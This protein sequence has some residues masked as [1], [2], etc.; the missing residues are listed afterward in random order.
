MNISGKYTFKTSISNPPEIAFLYSRLTAEDELFEFTTPTTS[1]RRM[2]PTNPVNPAAADSFFC[3]EMP[4]NCG[5]Y[6]TLSDCILRKL[7]PK[8]EPQPPGIGE[9][10]PIPA[11]QITAVFSI[12]ENGNI[13]E[14]FIIFKL[15]GTVARGG[16]YGT[17]GS[18]K[19]GYLPTVPIS[20][21]II[22][23][24][25]EIPISLNSASVG[26]NVV[27]TKWN[28]S[29]F[30]ENFDIFYKSPESRPPEDPV[31]NASVDLDYY[32]EDHVSGVFGLSSY[33]G[34]ITVNNPSI[35]EC[36]AEI[37]SDDWYFG[38]LENYSTSQSEQHIFYNEWLSND[39]G[40][41][42]VVFTGSL[43]QLGDFVALLGQLTSY[44]GLDG[45]ATQRVIANPFGCSYL[46]DGG[47][48]LPPD[49][50]PESIPP[51][52]S[53]TYYGRYSEIYVNFQRGKN[54]QEIKLPIRFPTRATKVQYGNSGFYDSTISPTSGQ[55]PVDFKWNSELFRGIIEIDQDYIWVKILYAPFREWKA[56]EKPPALKYLGE[57]Y[58]PFPD[59]KEWTLETRYLSFPLELNEV[60]ENLEYAEKTGTVVPKI[61]WFNRCRVFK[62]QKY[63]L[64][65]LEDI[66]YS[67]GDEQTI[68]TATWT[69]EITNSYIL[70][71]H[72]SEVKPIRQFGVN[73][74]I[75]PPN[76]VV[77]PNAN[78][79][80][81]GGN[82]LIYPQIGLGV[83]EREFMLL[84]SH[85]FSPYLK[86][87]ENWTDLDWIFFLLCE[88]PANHFTDYSFTSDFGNRRN[89]YFNT[90][91][92]FSGYGRIPKFETNYDPQFG[93]DYTE[94][95][96]EPAICPYD[97]IDRI[98]EYNRFIGNAIIK[99]GLIQ[100]YIRI[101][102]NSLPI[103]YIKP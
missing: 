8:Y 70:L 7:D 85:T 16:F 27:A 14:N 13:S 54:V 66:T 40:T 33:G 57:G 45:V 6:A 30:I 23:Q 26:F 88:S 21:A 5:N 20:N 84:P 55:Q 34:W 51:V 31:V 38:G 28:A 76:G 87:Q 95:G 64:Q 52:T 48:G 10:P 37:P 80:A 25:L 68:S 98:V 101:N 47:S 93:R 82:P 77:A 32:Q 89:L 90:P 22:F 19:I 69:H 73:Q 1:W 92:K 62:I 102:P 61:D 72:Q 86:P 24:G 29:A 97:Y 39:V 100:R 67:R 3:H 53:A 71:D 74:R 18:F 75:A 15:G 65:I 49:P 9:P 56:G 83:D 43:S 44:W 36:M 81:W 79:K 103:L 96:G 11:E 50:D 78:L 99:D 59:N 46:G 4:D 91:G 42:Y 17:T 63:P 2:K 41:G 58:E 60:E 94:I 35:T 12:G